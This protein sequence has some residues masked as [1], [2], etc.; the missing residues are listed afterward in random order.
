MPGRFKKNI[1]SKFST[2]KPSGWVATGQFFCLCFFFFYLELHILTMTS[3]ATF[4]CIFYPWKTDFTNMEKKLLSD[5][6]DNLDDISCMVD[7][8]WTI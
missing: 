8:C 2:I 4:R 3:K 7:L 5:K 1:N 6:I